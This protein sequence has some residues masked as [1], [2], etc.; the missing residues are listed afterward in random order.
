ME[1]LF[2]HTLNSPLSPSAN[3]RDYKVSSA[4]VMDSQA[5]LNERPEGKPTLD[6]EKQRM[7]DGTKTESDGSQSGEV[8]LDEYPSGA[9]LALIVMA[10]ILSNFLVALDLTIVG[11]AIPEI[12][13][14]FNTI[15][16][17]SW[18]G[19]AFFMTVGGFQATWG[20]AYKYFPLKASYLVS[21]FIFELGSLICGVAPTSTALIVGRA[22]S[23]VGAA[24]IGSG[25]FTITSF[26][27][28]P[29]KRPT[30]IGI[31]GLSYGVASAVGPLIGGAFTTNV[32]WRWCF[33]INLPVGGVAALIVLIFFKT[34]SKAKPTPAPLTEK[35]LQMDPVGTALVMGAIISFIL[36][37]QYGGQTHPWNS[38]TVIGLLVGFGAMVI[39]F[40]IWEYLQG[41]RATLVPRLVS[42]RNIWVNMVYSL[43]LSASKFAIIYYLPIY[44]QSIDNVSAS[45]SGVWTLPSIVAFSISMVVSGG[46]IT[47]TGIAS[48][49][50]VVGAAIATV[51]TGLLYTLDIGTG[52]GKWIGYQILSGVGWGL[53]FQV[54]IIVAQNVVAPSDI[55]PAIAI[56]LFFQT[57]GGA[58]GVSA[59]Q[60]AFVNQ[61]LVNV[62]KVA[63]SVDPEGLVAVGV[64]SLRDT[65]TADQ[66]PGVLLAYMDGLKAAFAVSI[67]MA[68]VAFLLSFLSK[69]A[70]I[71]VQL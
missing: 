6:E 1:T 36:A 35:L 34:P 67:G 64:T 7:M 40:G 25:V 53:A 28:E 62:P 8:S 3:E 48:P 14:E 52:S 23:G 49:I 10:L 27:A 43:F 47:K 5:T 18:Y 57:F 30:L 59:A 15:S 63:P 12:T 22:I 11:T 13:R 46:L 31:V 41:E 38:S 70:R 29:K 26:S 51:G 68:G 71:N 16:D 42:D 24:G 58:F 2:Y 44:F 60:A 45:T 55:P 56:V 4:A 39:A 21:I 19:S 61:I 9:G 66:M 17:V 65:Y 54:P 69:W 20:K 50:L 33:Y 32:T 37:L